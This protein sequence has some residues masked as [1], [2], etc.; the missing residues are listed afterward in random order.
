MPSPTEDLA[1]YLWTAYVAELQPV[2][3]QPLPG[4]D[5][6]DDFTRG[7][8]VKLAGLS[9]SFWTDPPPNS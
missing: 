2:I 5:E 6:L 1:R 3:D 9:M 4:W 8:W 7:V